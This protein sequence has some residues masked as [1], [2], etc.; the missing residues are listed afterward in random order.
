MLEL[1]VVCGIIALLAVIA[2][3]N[4]VR[5]RT[6]T[7]EATAIGNLHALVETLHT[8]H[9]VNNVFPATWQTDLYTEAD[10]DY[11]PP[12]FNMLMTDSSLQNYLYTYTAQPGGC[13][14]DCTGYTITANPQALGSLGTRAFFLDNTG[15]VRHCTGAGPADATDPLVTDPPAAC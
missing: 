6:T 4:L 5:A 13:A 15:R 14:T 7:N 8:Y 1:M 10:P 11:G 3:Q 9:A 2:I 12:A